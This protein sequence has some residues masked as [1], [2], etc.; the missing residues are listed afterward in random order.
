MSGIGFIGHMNEMKP[1]SCTYKMTISTSKE[2]SEVFSAMNFKE[3]MEIAMKKAEALGRLAN[4]PFRE[5][6]VAHLN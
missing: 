5:I 3:A 4:E 6:K 1:K 2:Y